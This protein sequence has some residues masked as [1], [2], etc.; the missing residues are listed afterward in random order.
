MATT[1]EKL[2][3]KFSEKNKYSNFGPVLKGMYIDGFR[4][5]NEIN[6]S[7]DFPIIVISGL[8]GAGK[9]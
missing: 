1:V 5:I 4:G 8:N 3:K 6:L 9:R 2:K 7:F